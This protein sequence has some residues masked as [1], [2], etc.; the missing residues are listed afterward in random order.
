MNDYGAMVRR[1][2]LMAHDKWTAP[3]WNSK[4]KVPS[5]RRPGLPVER[6]PEHN[7]EVWEWKRP[8]EDI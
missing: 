2:M 4:E 1:L 3:T 5:K 8:G 6:Q 7:R